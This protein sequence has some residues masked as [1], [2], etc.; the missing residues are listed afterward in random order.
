MSPELGPASQ[1][2]EWTQDYWGIENQLHY[3]R[4]VTLLEDATRISNVKQAQAM[5]VLNNFIVGLTSKLGLSNLAS[6][7]RMFDATLTIALSRHA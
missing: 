7:Q 5:A 3:R 4:D 6:A 2:L 1:L